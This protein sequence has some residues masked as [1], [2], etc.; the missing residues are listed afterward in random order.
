MAFTPGQK[1]MAAASGVAV[2]ATVCAPFAAYAANTA[3]S[4]VKATVG[5]T[6]SITSL[7][8]I[9]T[10]VLNPGASAV[11]SRQKDTIQVNCNSTNGY[12]VSLSN[13]SAT[14]SGL[15]DGGNSIAAGTGTKASPVALSAGQWGYALTGGSPFS[16]S[17]TAVANETSSA[18][19]W[20]G[21]PLSGSPITIV[22]KTG[23]ATNDNTDVWYGAKVDSSQ[24]TSATG[25]AATV[26]YTATAK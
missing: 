26:V 1:A 4:T 14:I 12:T 23:V 9:P 7:G 11:E 22:D 20:A 6:I 18:D 21:V 16:A 13:T 17:Y 24:P 15:V 25:Y 19:L 2:L 8:T 3:N 10:L 5:S